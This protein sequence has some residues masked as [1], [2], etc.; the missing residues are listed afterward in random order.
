MIYPAAPQTNIR[1][2][3]PR[4]FPPDDPLHVARL[5]RRDVA[6]EAAL[7]ENGFTIPALDQ[8]EDRR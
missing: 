4:V 5:V 7:R 6:L 2:V 8:D 3:A 1:S